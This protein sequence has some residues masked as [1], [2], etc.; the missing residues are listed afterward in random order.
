MHIICNVLETKR[1]GIVNFD[2]SFHSE[3]DLK[4]PFLE[5]VCVDDFWCA[6]SKSWTCDRYTLR[7]QQIYWKLSLWADEARIKNLLQDQG[8]SWRRKPWK[9]FRKTASNIFL[10]KRET[11]GK[12]LRGLL[13][14]GQGVREK[15]FI[16]GW[17]VV[18]VGPVFIYQCKGNMHCSRW[19]RRD[20]SFS[21]SLTQ[22]DGLIEGCGCTPFW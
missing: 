20:W 14:G 12:K 10:G 3:D 8:V 16:V 15:V 21:V 7:I 17:R 13:G 18:V 22:I 4:G 11:C 9:M 19:G 5:Y 1:I 6:C 2:C